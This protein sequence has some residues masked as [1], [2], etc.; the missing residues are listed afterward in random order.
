M[1]Q[2]ELTTIYCQMYKS[3]RSTLAEVDGGKELSYLGAQGNN[4]PSHV[5][6]FTQVGG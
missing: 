6:T 5:Q 4:T 3:N 1:I 2:E